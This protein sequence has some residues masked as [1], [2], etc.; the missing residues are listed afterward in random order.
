VA[1]W[2]GPEAS[3]ATRDRVRLMQ[4]HAFEVQLAATDVP[5]SH[6]TEPDLDAITAPALLVAGAHD[7][8]DFREIAATLADRL[9]GARHL[10]LGWAGHLP[11]LERPDTVNQLLIGFLREV[12]PVG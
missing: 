3:A 11:S 6:R 12:L 8:T 10:E 5:P 7:L 4:R 2:V 1:T 9:P